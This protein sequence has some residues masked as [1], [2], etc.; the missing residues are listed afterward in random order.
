MFSNAPSRAR[1]Q[2]IAARDGCRCFYCGRKYRAEA[3]TLEHVIA[4]SLGGSD[5]PGNIVLACEPCN[6][7][8]GSKSVVNKLRM[9]DA[10]RHN[11][12]EKLLDRIAELES[13]NQTQL[14]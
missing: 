7:E 14:G 1:R 2:M 12:V 10:K 11:T 13:Q 8:A 3:L 5:T 6:K 9:R 4:L